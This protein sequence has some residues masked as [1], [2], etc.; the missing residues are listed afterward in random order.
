[1]CFDREA[2]ILSDEFQSKLHKYKGM[3]AFGN[4][5]ISKELFKFMNK[6]RGVDLQCI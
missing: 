1:M 4:T 2:G 5:Q 3:N 6:N